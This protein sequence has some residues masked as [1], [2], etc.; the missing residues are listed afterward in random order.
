MDKIEGKP[1][2]VKN[3]LTGKDNKTYDVVRVIGFLGG[4]AFILMSMFVVYKTTVF[5]YIDFGIGL[6]SIIVAIG[7]GA[8]LKETTEPE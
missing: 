3:M 5:N 1:Y 8:K 4:I 2:L 6:A 7:G